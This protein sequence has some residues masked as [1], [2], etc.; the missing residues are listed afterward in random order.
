MKD[1]QG[2]AAVV[3]GAASGIGRAMALDFAR[4]GMKV[5]AAD[6]EQEPL[7]A[8]AAEIEAEGAECLTV[9]TDVSDRQAVQ[10]LAAAAFERFGA[11]HVLCNNAG[12]ASGGGLEEAT[13]QDW[14]W[15]LGVNL[16][17]V[18]HG[19]LAFVPRM[20]EQRQGG[21]IV[22]TGSMAG[23]IASKGLGV[24]NTSKYAVVGL[25]ETLARDLRDHG[26]GVSVLCPMGVNTRIRE[27]MRNRPETLKEEMSAY[28][29]PD[30]VGNTISPEE[31]SRLVLNAIEQEELYVLTHPESEEFVARRFERIRKAFR[32]VSG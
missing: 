24:Y 20:I 5:V 10:E 8:V 7:T 32:H 30:L 26:I 18:I 21:H 23:L 25:S 2:K 12:V 19:I 11:V 27:S 16:W 29:P 9:R 28:E 1:F 22:N 13:F 6:I 14:Q 15:V 4:R 31:T 17:G 3:T